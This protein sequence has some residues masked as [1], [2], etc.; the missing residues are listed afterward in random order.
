MRG[1][2][3]VLEYDTKTPRGGEITIKSATTA[4]KECE[5]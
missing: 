1:N 4:K 2:E 3:N 5:S